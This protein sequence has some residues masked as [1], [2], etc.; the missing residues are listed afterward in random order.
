MQSF[1]IESVSFIQVKDSS[2]GFTI[3]INYLKFKTKKKQ[4]NKQIIISSN[5]VN[6]LKLLIN[7]SSDKKFVLLIWFCLKLGN[8]ELK[9]H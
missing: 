8:G 5:L 2:S 6:K 9:I 7:F 1:S 3:I 4:I